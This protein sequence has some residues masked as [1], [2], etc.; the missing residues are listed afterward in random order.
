MYIYIFSG[1]IMVPFKYMPQAGSEPGTYAILSTWIWD[2][3]LDHSATTAGYL[4]IVVLVLLSNPEIL[5]ISFLLKTIHIRQ[6]NWF[7]PFL[8]SLFLAQ[9][10]QFQPNCNCL[11]SLVHLLI[12]ILHW[13]AIT[14]HREQIPSIILLIK[15]RFLRATSPLFFL[16]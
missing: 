13:K 4:A 2:S 1:S 10:A 7:K 6:S 3:V 15:I 8:F 16:V 14:N 12:V 5:A 11:S 9:T